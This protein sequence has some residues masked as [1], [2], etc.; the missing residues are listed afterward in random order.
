MAPAASAEVNRTSSV[1]A[2]ENRSQNR[3]AKPPVLM[4]MGPTASGKTAVALVLAK[5]F[6]VEI[7]SVDSAMVYRGMDIGT[8]KPDAQ[9]LADVPHHLIDIIAPDERYSA[10]QFCTDARRLIAGIRARG[11]IPLL[12]GGTMLYFKALRLGLADLPSADT[13]LREQIEHQAAAHGWPALH[14]RLA[15]VDPVSAARIDRNDAQRIQRA[16]EIVHL[17]GKPLAA[18]WQREARPDYNAGDC[19]DIDPPCREIAV[20]LAP[21]DRSELHRRIAGRFDS[22]LSLGLIDELR[23]LRARYPLNP[24][25]PSM[26]CVG[27]RQGWQYLNGEYD[28]ATLRE[29]GIAATRQLAKRQLTWLRSTPFDRCFD[30]LAP[31][32]ERQL[33]DFLVTRI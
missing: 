7:I 16:L 20:A 12:A 9:T 3:R 22:M 28:Y 13:L 15:G 24:E 18:A 17:T 10:A 14:A 1:P 27:Y 29:K 6:P 21:D 25:M 33:M 31:D 32:L 4:L 26:R 5:R 19:A 23:G 30:C 8:A 2:Q 11:N